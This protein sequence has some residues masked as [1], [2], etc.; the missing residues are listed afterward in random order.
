MSDLAQKSTAGI[1]H[2]G[3][4]PGHL[5]AFLERIERM[6]SEVKAAQEE[7]KEVFAEVKSMGLD[8]KIVKA[9]VKLRAM[10]PSERHEAD[11]MM[12]LYRTAARL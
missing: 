8:V 3:I 10:D 2:N 1:G 6:D 5:N 4:D 7:R 12:D 11:V 9:I